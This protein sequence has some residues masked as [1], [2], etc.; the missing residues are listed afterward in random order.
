M[1]K[2]SYDSDDDEWPEIRYRRIAAQRQ[3]ITTSA[4][5][6]YKNT[7]NMSPNNRNN[8]NNMNNINNTKNNQHYSPLLANPY[9]TAHDNNPRQEHFVSTPMASTGNLPHVCS[10][11]ISQKISN[12]NGG[13]MIHILYCILLFILVILLSIS[14]GIYVG[15][16]VA[17]GRSPH[18]AST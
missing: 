13:D 16:K 14:G 1:N 17:G 11:C 3:G 12:I 4:R 9:I 6:E 8:V 15:Y 18:A 5:N 2:Y 10:Q 7:A